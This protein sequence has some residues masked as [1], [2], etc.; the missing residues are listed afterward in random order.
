[1]ITED[2]SEVV[3]FLASPSTHGGA[4][5]ERI[6]TH[7][8]IVFLAGTRAWKLKRAVQ[9]DYLD[10]STVERRKDD[11]RGRSADQSPYCTGPLSRGG[12]GDASARRIV[13]A[14]RI[15]RAGGLA[16]R[17]GPFRS[18]GLFDRLAGRGALDLALMRPLATAIAQFHETAERRAD[19]G[20]AAGMAWVVDGNAAGFA[21]QGAGIFD[22]AACAD[23]TRSSREHTRAA[24]MRCSTRDGTVAS[25]GSATAICTCAT[26]SC[27]TA[28]RRCSTRSNATTRL[29]AATCSTTWRSCSWTC[30]GASFR[31]MRTPSGTGTWPRRADLGGIPLLPLF[32][33]CRA[34]V[35]AKTSATAAN[36]QSDPPRQSELQEMARDYLAMAQRLLH[37]PPACL[38]A[39]G[40]FSGSGKSTLARALAPL[41][42][43]V[44]GAVVIRS[45]ET[46]KQLCGV[47]PFQRLGPE[48]YTA[49][50]TRR[51]YAMIAQRAAQVMTGGHAAIVDAVYARPADREA[52][53]RVAV[54][55]ARAIRRRVARGTRCGLDRPV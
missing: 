16:R 28:T 6:E 43:A 27:S 30:G 23:L 24:S 19:H 8:S 41:I 34:A 14:R 10:F 29:P 55:G 12:G 35:R 37:P 9:Y 11:V 22:P 48:G 21:E 31:D 7:A 45:D 3:T 46:R 40:G 33:S 42:G 2:Q 52:I 38:I 39:L 50:V 32:L 26:S 47:D 17:D 13:G 54:R 5:V 1:M 15:R 25:S 44:P 20:G 36:L 4:V 49:E 53:E 51:V 18:G